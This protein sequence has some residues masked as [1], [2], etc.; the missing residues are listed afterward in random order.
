MICTHCQEDKDL[1]LFSRTK[2]TKTGYNHWCKACYREWQIANADRLADYWRGYYREN[3]E[4]ARERR[5]AYYA[6]HRTEA[7]AR[8]WR[9]NNPDRRRLWSRIWKH[10]HKDA[11]NHQTRIRRT[12]I[13]RAAT[14]LTGEQWGRLVDAAA[15]KCA[16]CGADCANPEADHLIPVKMGGGYVWGNI[17]PACRTCNAK[18]V[19][20]AP[21]E[22][23]GIRKY[24]DLLVSCH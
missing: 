8:S 7:I 15:G 18:K 1:P 9:E 20:K 21:I 2:R 23:L 11:V 22:F 3:I 5:A 6:A 17:F 4:L 13:G 19:A 24:V 12:R 10:N 14:G 16:Y